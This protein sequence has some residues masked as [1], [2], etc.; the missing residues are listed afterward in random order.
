MASR[1]TP[2]AM[3]N[4]PDEVLAKILARV[5]LGKSKV[6]MQS[7]AKQWQ[8]VLHLRAAHSIDTFDEDEGMPA[9]PNMV[10]PTR[11]TP[12]VSPGLLNAL[13]CYRVTSPEP[14]Q[15]LAGLPSGLG[16]LGIERVPSVSPMFLCV[17]KLECTTVDV[18]LSPLFPNLEEVKFGAIGDD[19][20]AKLPA[21]MSDLQGLPNLRRVFV[22][23]TKSFVDFHGP[24]GC[25]VHYSICGPRLDVVP[26]GLARHIDEL[27]IRC[28]WSHG[29]RGNKVDLAA[30]AGCSLLQKIQIIAGGEFMG[31]HR[32]L[33]ICGLGKLP[34]SC[35]T[36][37]ANVIGFDA[38]A[39]KLPMV[40]PENGWQ[41]NV[42]RVN[43]ELMLRL[44]RVPIV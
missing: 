24:P 26:E 31:G 44:A 42:D 28:Y 18:P 13:I 19:N 8:R 35:M 21:V 12:R 33:L 29:S 2:Q 5:P 11:A 15:S 20:S 32:P 7:V 37:L 14:W 43:S 9:T 6:A 27:V 36:V 4:L 41:I 17:R 10:T 1:D 25:R 22:R 23:T 34:A 39:G 38:E 30:V 3:S 16:V 40:Y